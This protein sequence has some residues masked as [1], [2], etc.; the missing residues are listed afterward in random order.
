MSY[1]E[2]LSSSDQR[3][4]D[5][6]QQCRTSGLSDSQWLQENNIKSPTFYYHVKQ[7]RKKTCE[8]PENT[9]STRSD[10]QEVVPLFIKDTTNEFPNITSSDCDTASIRLNINGI[11]IEITNG[12]TQ[13]VIRNTIASLQFLC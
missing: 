9:H 5:L 1:P 4:F 7:L 11:S 6:I 10:L 3:W 2:H 13:E 12:A 8:I